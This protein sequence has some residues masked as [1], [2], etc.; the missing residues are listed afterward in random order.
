MRR[1]WSELGKRIRRIDPADRQAAQILGGLALVV[2]GVP[3]VREVG[4]LAAVEAVAEE[5]AKRLVGKVAE[6]VNRRT[7]KN[8]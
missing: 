3:V 7:V 4:A 5:P 2:S 8:R 1:A 6:L